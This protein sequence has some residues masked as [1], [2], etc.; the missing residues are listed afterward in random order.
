MAA[1]VGLLDFGSV[2]LSLLSGA[3]ISMGFIQLLAPALESVAN[4]NVQ[5]LAVLTTT[6]A[7]PLVIS[8]LVLL[9]EGPLLVRLGG[10]LARRPPRWLLRLWLQQVKGLTLACMGLVP[11]MLAAA[12]LAATLTRPEISSLAELQFLASN[13][14]PPLLLLALFKT[15]LFAS[16]VLWISLDQGA[17]A[18][19][20]RLSG[21]AALSRAITVSMAVL[22]GVDLFWVLALAPNLSGGMAGP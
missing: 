8:L 5:V 18:G 10:K 17:R 3:L 16:L 12:M 6:L 11:Y 19:R 13:L 20:Q 21:S 22:L 2:G 1:R 9:R 4:V 7:A 15:G 14:N